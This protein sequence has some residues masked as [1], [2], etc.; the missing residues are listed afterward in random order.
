MDAKSVTNKNTIHGRKGRYE[1]MGAK[2]VTGAASAIKLL[3][4]QFRMAR[5]T[6]TERAKEATTIKMNG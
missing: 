2:G 4:Q 6:C 1:H 5:K 3:F